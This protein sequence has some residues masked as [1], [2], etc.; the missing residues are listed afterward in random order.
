MVIL[1]R[2]GLSL[3]PSAIKKLTFVCFRLSI[4]PCLVEAIT[5]AAASFFAFGL[6]WSWSLMLGFVVAS[7][8]PAVVVPAMIELQDKEL[9]LD[10]GIP[11]LIIAAASI[12]NVIAI[13]G[14][15]VSFS[16][17][18]TNTDQSSLVWALLKG[19]TE[20]VIGIMFGIIVGFLL[21]YIPDS[22]NITPKYD[23]HR[24]LILL[25]SS[26]FALFG[27]NQLNFTAS[28][29]MAI[30][31][32]SFVASLRWR[33]L[34]FATF[35][36]DSLK[37]IWLVLEHYLFCLIAADVRVKTIQSD[38]ILYGLTCLLVALVVRVIAA[39]LVTYGIGLNHNERLFIS[40]AWIPKASI[41]V[42]MLLM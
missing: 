42:G 28:G 16:L 13:T 40:I 7:V 1:L 8:S 20:A 35:N 4:V 22:K 18:F 31:V 37:K 21:W 41:Q 25:F 26:T 9:G 33:P 14:F 12:D 17:A 19:P 39:Y 30:L 38:V 3:D 27:S 2:A 10:K 6:N 36:E 5:L 24:F 29:P 23:L 32:L 15:S 11:T 34:G